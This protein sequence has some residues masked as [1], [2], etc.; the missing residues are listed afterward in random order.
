MLDGFRPA[1]AELLSFG[2]SV[3][4]KLLRNR[5]VKCHGYMKTIFNISVLAILLAVVPSPCLAEGTFGTT[6]TREVAK[7]HGMEVRANAIDINRVTVELEIKTEGESRF[8]AKLERVELQISKGAT[9]LVS[10][11]L[12]EEQSKPGHVVVRFTADRAQLETITL[13]VCGTAMGRVIYELPMKVLVDL[14][15]AR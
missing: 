14:E 13:R 7:Q 15:K 9:N 11:T 5:R 12:R 1:V 4:R 10:A 6:T 3:A 8:L 2:G